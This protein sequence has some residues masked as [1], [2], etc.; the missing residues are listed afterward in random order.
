M[1]WQK[2][3]TAPKD[4]TAILL[5]CGD[6]RDRVSTAYWSKNSGYGNGPPD[7]QLCMPGGYAETDD[8]PVKPTHWMPLPP[9][10]IDED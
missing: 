2:I 8:L 6:G 10:P 9:P 5:Y 7:W 1:N 3:E 4:G